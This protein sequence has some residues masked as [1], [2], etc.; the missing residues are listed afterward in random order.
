MEKASVLFK[1]IMLALLLAVMALALLCVVREGLESRSYLLALAMGGL[2]AL[3]LGLL[4]RR[5]ALPVPRRAG[6]TAALVCFVLNLAW[7]LLVRIEPFSDYEEYWTVAC[8]LSAGAPIPDAWYVAMYPHLLGTASFLSGLIRLFGPSVTAVTVVNTLLTSLSCLV[9]WAL[10]RALFDEESAFLAALLWAVTPCKLMLGSLVF[11]EPLYT[12]L[13][14][15]FLLLAVRLDARWRSGGGRTLFAPLWGAL[16]GLVLLAVNII[17]PIAAILVIA[18]LLWLLLLR[19]RELGSAALWR[20]WGPAV[21]ALL[22]VYAAGGRLWTRHAERVLGQEVASVPW[23]NVYVGFNEETEGRYTDADMDLLTS[24]LRQ[25][26][27]A[28]E[29]QRSMIPHVKERLRSGIDFPR[30]LSAKLFAFLGNDELGGYTYRFTRSELFVK[31]CM[32][33]CNVFYYGV[34]LAAMRALLRELRGRAL[35]A[36]QLLPLFFLGLTLAHM[37][38]EVANRYHYSLIPILLIFAARGLTGAERSET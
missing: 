21:L 24:Y 38:V 34:F 26:Q 9:I 27:S 12:L 13:I 35:T 30:L 25:G 3:G 31:L 32:G 10:A 29:A 33:I 2:W 20:R 36:G 23:Y 4:L 11:S 16:L 15:V 22:L 19:G 17:R 1:R 5:H 7:V 14:L 37:L 28:N 18:L 8:A 6:L